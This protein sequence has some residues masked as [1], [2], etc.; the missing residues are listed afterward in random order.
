MPANVLA[1]DQIM[2]A[3]ATLLPP[4]ALTAAQSLPQATTTSATNNE[5]NSGSSEPLAGNVPNSNGGDNNNTSTGGSESVKG[6][7]GLEARVALKNLS[8]ALN[9]ENKDNT[10]TSPPLPTSTPPAEAVASSPAAEVAAAENTDDG[11]TAPRTPL[12]PLVQGCPVMAEARGRGRWFS[13]LITRVRTG[14]ASSSSSSGVGSS[15]GTLGD[16]VYDVAYDDGETETG[17]C[18][19]L[20]APCL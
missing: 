4:L 11:P 13:G 7:I 6:G 10:T 1:V 5:T 20:L 2:Q 12:R 16:W 3:A 8:D 17:L 15:G 14:S 19:A 18:G 9:G